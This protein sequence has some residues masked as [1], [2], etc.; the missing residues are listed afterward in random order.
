[1]FY[2]WRCTGEGNRLKHCIGI[3]I[4]WYYFS[5]RA[6]TFVCFTISTDVS[7]TAMKLSRP[8]GFFFGGDGGGVGSGSDVGCI[9]YGAKLTTI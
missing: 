8:L 3:G 4:G 6:L 7:V 2:K 5:R 1:M 9:V